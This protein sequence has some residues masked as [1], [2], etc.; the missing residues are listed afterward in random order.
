LNIEFKNTFETMNSQALDI[1]KENTG[2]M[3]KIL[4]MD[5]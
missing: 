2:R 5:F 4:P 1:M 3:D